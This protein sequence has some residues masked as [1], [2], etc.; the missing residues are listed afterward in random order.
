MRLHVLFVATIC[1]FVASLNQA[2]AKSLEARQ[3]STI[4]DL[5]PDENVTIIPLIEAIGNPSKRYNMVP[6][7]AVTAYVL[8]ST[9]YH[10]TFWIIDF[11]NDCTNG[12]MQ[13]K[14]STSLA[15]MPNTWINVARNPYFS[16]MG[17]PTF[18]IALGPFVPCTTVYI[19]ARLRYGLKT[20]HL[21][22]FSISTS[23]PCDPCICIGD[24]HYS[25]FGDKKFDFNRPCS[26]VLSTTI[27][28]SN[29]SLT[30]IA[31]HSVG[32]PSVSIESATIEADGHTVVLEED[33]SITIENEPCNGSAFVCPDLTVA[34]ETI[35]QYTQM[36][37]SLTEKW[38]ILWKKN[39]H[40]N[41]NEIQFEI[42]DDSPLVGKQTGMLGP[43]FA[44]NEN[45][46]F[47]GFI[48]KNGSITFDA[49]E[50]GNSWEVS[51]SCPS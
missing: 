33:G 51:G 10:V 16:F 37:F 9:C 8:Y 1:L 24:P 13:I 50:H 48:M 35:D 23:C 32:R 2:E 41:R 15:T 22:M 40:T 42:E 43:K 26:Y 38:W 7:D 17:Y 45:H 39:P 46:P 11:S 36:L 12:K 30:L 31:K 14:Y 6:Y 18:T 28:P 25:D 49:I 27:Q 21:G 47:Q 34:V 4:E 44:D 3:D 5:Q 29:H 19:V 20:R